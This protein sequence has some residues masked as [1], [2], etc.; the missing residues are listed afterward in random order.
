MKR[1]YL[2]RV[3]NPRKTGKKQRRKRGKKRLKNA[4]NEEYDS[5]DPKIKKKYFY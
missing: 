5:L 1:V 4:G 2:I 3:D